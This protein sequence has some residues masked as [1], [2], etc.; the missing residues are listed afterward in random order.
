MRRIKIAQIGMNKNSHGPEVFAS[1]KKQSDIFEIVGYALP[2]NEKQTMPERMGTFDGYR[3]MT[4]EEIL[5]DREIEA[6]TVET[7]EIHLVRYAIMAAQA[8]KHIHMEKPGGV[9]PAGFEKL[10]NIVKKNKTVFHTGYMYRYNPCIMSLM[11]KVKSGELGEIISAEA[12]MSGFHPRNVRQWMENFPGGMMFYLG[13]HLV[14]LILQLQGEPERVIPL[15]KRTGMEGV[16]GEDFGMAIFEY[17]NGVSFAKTTD[18]E[19]GG[20]KRRQLVVTGTKG[21]VEI[22]PLE[23]A[24]E[25]PFL[26]TEYREVYSDGWHADAPFETTGGFDRY[27]SMMAAFGEMVR[28]EKENPWSYDYELM[29]YRYVLK[30]CGF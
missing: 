23:N 20:F 16:S 19:R 8:G 13:C 5:N 6:V 12:Q 7:D 14:D 27:D 4:V 1:I 25:Y 21:T 17:K 11:E 18:I 2:E 10:I 24:E 26:T 28:G 22:R 30:A 15:N 29:L 9:D 3:E